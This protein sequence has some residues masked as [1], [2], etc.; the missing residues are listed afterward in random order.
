MNADKLETVL[1]LGR[2]GRQEYYVQRVNYFYVDELQCFANS[3]PNHPSGPPTSRLEIMSSLTKKYGK[4]EAKN[5]FNRFIRKGILEKKGV[6]L[7][8]PIPSMHA[9]LISNYARD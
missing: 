8:V 6:E 2:K 7:A 1:N 3:L 4:R 9:W 5:L